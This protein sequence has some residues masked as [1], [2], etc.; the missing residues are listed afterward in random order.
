MKRSCV[1]CKIDI[2][3]VYLSTDD[4]LPNVRS[5]ERVKREVGDQETVCEDSDSREHSENH[6]A[7]YELESCRCVVL[8]CLP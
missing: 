7:I 1:K 4:A 8:V 2:S 6:E 5:E 3:G